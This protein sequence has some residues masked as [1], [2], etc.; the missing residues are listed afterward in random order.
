MKPSKLVVVSVSLLYRF[1]LNCVQCEASAYVFSSP[2]WDYQHCYLA[3]EAYI[4][5]DWTTQL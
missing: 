3:V 4:Q 2:Q 1:S 5:R